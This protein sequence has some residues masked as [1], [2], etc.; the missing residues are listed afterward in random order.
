MILKKKSNQFLSMAYKSFPKRWKNSLTGVAS[1]RKPPRG[2][3]S[4][5]R[6]HRDT[7]HSEGA[8]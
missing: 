3:G 2:K 6:L 4:E 1:Q 7:L 5:L 8:A